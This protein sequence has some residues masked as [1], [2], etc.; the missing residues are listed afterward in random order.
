MHIRVRKLIGTVL[1]LVLAIVW[2]L[3]AMAVAQFVLPS[4]DG[5]VAAIYYVAVGL[6]WLPL[7]MLLVSWMSRPDPEPT[8]TQTQD[9]S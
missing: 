5:W 8:S 3:V 1:L 2:A 7:A 6:G 9:E 4:V